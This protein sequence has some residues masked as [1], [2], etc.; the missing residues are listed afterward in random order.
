MDKKLFFNGVKRSGEYVTPP[1]GFDELFH[2]VQKT[3]L[4]L[5]SGWVLDGARERPRGD[6]KRR[7]IQDIERK[8]DLAQTGWAVV[9]APGIDRRVPAA[10]KDLIE[11]RESQ[12][13]GGGQSHLFRW[14]DARPGESL[15]D[16]LRRP[17]VAAGQ[18][19]DPD[20][21][22]YHVLLVGEPESLPFLFQQ[23]LD[24]GYAV[25]RICF[26][27]LED[28]KA[29]ARSVVRAET[30]QPVRPRQIAFFGTAHDND[31][32]TQQM[33]RELVQPLFESVVESGKGWDVSCAIGPEARKERLTRLLGGPETP[34]LL[35]A[36]C[37]GL[38]LDID[39]ER[40]REAQGALICQDWPG[41]DDKEG[42]DENQ[43]FAASNVSESASLQG[44][45]AF[46]IACYGVGTPARDNFDQNP[47]G[48]A[49]RLAKQA[50]V[51]R[52]PQRL[53][54]HPEG[55]A[56]AVVGHVDRAW[57][58]GF[59]GSPKGE[60]RAPYLNALKRLLEG[61]TIGWAVEDVN[62]KH[63]ALAAQ[64]ANLWES[65]RMRDKEVD[66]RQFS[67]LWSSRNDARNYVVFGDPAVRLPGVGEAR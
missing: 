48:K 7:P 64:L 55:G 45:I 62:F 46:F 36:A 15:D 18:R 14:I 33:A 9:F 19:G 16:F 53:L 51:S 57:V 17:D 23:E 5:P 6:P 29:Y 56:L 13:A 60:G 20:F 61:H 43:W 11:L 49:R 32:S 41:P 2:I 37:H 1:L 63:A 52:L 28:Y 3:G 35:F 10:L 26:D 30:K 24:V 42:V 8:W 39:D 31:P 21:F 34:A 27:R 65:Q 58:T 50:F 47:L 38:G 22:P 40:Q 54:S 67:Y 59:A 12:A 25:G 66:P 44:L 4:D